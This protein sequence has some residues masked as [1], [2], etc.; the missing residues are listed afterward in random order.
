MVSVA[1]VYLWNSLYILSFD[2]VI[3][4]LNETYFY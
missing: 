2:Y 3:S 4:A 1:V